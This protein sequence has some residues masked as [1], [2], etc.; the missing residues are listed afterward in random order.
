MVKKHLK[1]E[2]KLNKLEDVT[3]K[4]ITQMWFIKKCRCE[5]V[6]QT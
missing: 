6:K 1:F 4:S 3:T 5:F 2:I